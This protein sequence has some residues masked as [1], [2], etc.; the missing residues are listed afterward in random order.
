V[1][2]HVKPSKF[3][4]MVR[5]VLEGDLHV[6]GKP[7]ITGI[8]AE[9]IAP[10]LYLGKTPRMYHRDGS[11]HGNEKQRVCLLRARRVALRMD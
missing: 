2:I 8:Q 9:E 10:R 5:L 1:Y 7:L 6:T 11:K 4:V 3:E